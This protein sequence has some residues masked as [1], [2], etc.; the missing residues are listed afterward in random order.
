MAAA[1]V[2]PITAV[3]AMVVVTGTLLLRQRRRAR[4]RRSAEEAGALETALDVLV[5]ELRAGVH[6]VSA[7]DAAAAEAPA[8]VAASLS[9][10]AARARLGADVPAGLRSVAPG[11][12]VPMHWERLAV[13]WHLA[14][15]HGLG[16]ATLM[17]AA[18]RDIVERSQFCDRASAAMAGARTT[19]AVLAGL[20]VLGILFGELLGA[21][22]LR[23][24]LSGGAGG[25]LLVAGATLGCCG[26]MWSDRI[27]GRVEA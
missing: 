17:R 23:F 1:V 3:L 7:F 2:L 24:L 22:P 14:Q 19:A 20:P 6:P 25:W 11:S 4:R 18:Q 9:A 10:V 15:A 12:A 5:G 21:H 16:M 27:T 26:L 8:P 13:C